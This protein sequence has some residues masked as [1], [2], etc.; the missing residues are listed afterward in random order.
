M[1]TPT[2]H[3]RS[4]EERLF[5]LCSRALLAVTLFLLT[6]LWAK[7]DKIDEANKTR[8]RELAAFMLE[9]EHRM[10]AIETKVASEKRK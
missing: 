4:V 5:T 8:D 10:T 6:T 3:R 1:T 7:V 9:I 2:P